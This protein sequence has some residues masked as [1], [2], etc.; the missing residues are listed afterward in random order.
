MEII[1]LLSIVVVA[2]VFH[3]GICLIVVGVIKKNTK[4][5]TKTKRTW[6]LIILFLPIIGAVL[7]N[8]YFRIAKISP[9]ISGGR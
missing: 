2:L 9:G 1:N 3:L 7:A 6:Y 5:S 8:I 4:L